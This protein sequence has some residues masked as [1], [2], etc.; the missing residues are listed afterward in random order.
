M[1][2]EI[3]G[4]LAQYLRLTFDRG[5]TCRAVASSRPGPVS[6]W[7]R[8]DGPLLTTRGSLLAAW[9]RRDARR[10]SRA[11]PPPR[12]PLPLPLA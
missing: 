4:Q 11:T 5:E 7:N 2:Q 10:P 6:L 3:H 12:E 8:A 1:H 9:G